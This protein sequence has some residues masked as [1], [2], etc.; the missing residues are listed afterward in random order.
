MV[1]EAA[2]E[3]TR[4]PETKFFP[5]P[6]DILRIA[7]GWESSFMGDRLAYAAYLL[8]E[9]PEKVQGSLLAVVTAF[10]RGKFAEMPDVKVETCEVMGLGFEKEVRRYFSLE[11]RK[12]DQAWKKANASVSK[13]QRARERAIDRGA[14]GVPSIEVA[15]LKLAPEPDSATECLAEGLAAQ[16]R[17]A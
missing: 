5:T 17:M 8:H 9:S 6:G 15:A 7:K 13:L 1:F 11:S 14:H 3:Y 4:E 12:W 16:K 2:L 10:G